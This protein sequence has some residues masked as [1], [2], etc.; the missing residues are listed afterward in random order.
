MLSRFANMGSIIRQGMQF[1]EPSS[2]SFGLAC[3]DFSLPPCVFTLALCCKELFFP[4]SF[5][6]LSFSLELHEM[7]AVKAIIKEASKMKVAIEDLLY[8]NRFIIFSLII[9]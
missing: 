1:L 6:E 4:A 2:R 9:Q 7:S 5:W 8:L 3:E